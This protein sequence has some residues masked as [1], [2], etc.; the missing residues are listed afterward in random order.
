MSRR[1]A[2]WPVVACA[3]ALYVAWAAAFFA[4]GHE[5]RDFIKIGTRFVLRSDASDVIRFDPTYRYPPNHDSPNGYGFDG[6]TSYYIALDPEHAR[7]YLDL[8]A[9]RYARVLYPAAARALAAG[10]PGLVPWTLILVNLVAIGAGVLA[11]AAWLRRHSCSPWFALIFGFYPGLLLAFQ[12]DLTEPLA[13]AL[14]PIA[15]YVFDFGGRRRLAWAGLLFALAVLARQTTAVFALCYAGAVLLSGDPAL[16]PAVR[17][18]SNLARAAGFLLLA[19]GP[20]AAYSAFLWAWLGSPGTSAPG[21]LTPVPFL[22]LVQA[23]HWQLSRQ[24][25]EAIGVIVPALIVTA[26]AVAAWRA[27]GPRVE[28]ACLI[29]NAILFVVLLGPNPYRSITSS[30]RVAMGVVVASVLAIPSF[31][32]LGRRERAALVVAAGLALC[33]L[34]VIAVY[35]FTDARV[36]HNPV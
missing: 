24:P 1:R 21:N 19:L 2:L 9:F 25:P 20:M 13:Y 33:L 35:G 34:P 3:L 4:A 10:R 36:S 5:A 30:G 18:R 22:G 11:L 31:A 26:V 6:Q 32:A 14:V 8:P 23:D 17:A 29:A 28:L 12:R 27:E 15:V 7:F 16:A